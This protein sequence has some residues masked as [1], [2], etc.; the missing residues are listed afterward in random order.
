[1]KKNIKSFLDFVNEEI[2]DEYLNKQLDKANQEGRKISTEYRSNILSKQNKL[3][4]DDNERQVK[5]AVEAREQKNKKLVSISDTL[6]D[7]LG[8][9]SFTFGNYGETIVKVTAGSGMLR[10]DFSNSNGDRILEIDCNIERDIIEVF[11]IEK[12]TNRKTI[13][14]VQRVESFF[15]ELQK[16]Y[17]EFFPESNY[18]NRKIWSSL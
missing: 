7:R 16:M 14:S 5:S 13:I 17:R 1:M 12:D 18:A 6:N 9:R 8:N 15:T 4:Y 2:S 11:E 3:K 10:F